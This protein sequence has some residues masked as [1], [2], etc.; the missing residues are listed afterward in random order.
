M[1]HVHADWQFLP[2]MHVLSCRNGGQSAFWSHWAPQPEPN[3][4]PSPKSL[5]LHV[6]VNGP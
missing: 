3:A 4:M 5:S 2:K 1:L 6:W